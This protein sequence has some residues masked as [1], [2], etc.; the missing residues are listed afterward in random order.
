MGY[1]NRS[2]VT[3]GTWVSVEEGSDVHCIVCRDE[4]SVMVHFG[5]A[6]FELVLDRGMLEQC[7]TRFTEALRTLTAA[8]AP[9][10]ITA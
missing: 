2:P 7:V 8:Q 6:D 10:A 3:I 9:E 1:F 4:K 5:D